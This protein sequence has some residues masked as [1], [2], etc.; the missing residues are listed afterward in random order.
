MHGCTISTGVLQLRSFGLSWRLSTL[1]RLFVILKVCK[2]SFMDLVVC[3]NFPARQCK[4]LATSYCAVKCFLC[5]CCR[6]EAWVVSTYIVGTKNPE[7]GVNTGKLIGNIA[8][9]C[10]CA[11]GLWRFVADRLA[12][13]RHIF[14]VSPLE[15]VVEPGIKI[16]Q[17]SVMVC[18][19]LSP[20]T[21]LESRKGATYSSNS[22]L[23]PVARAPPFAQSM[24]RFRRDFAPL[25]VGLRTLN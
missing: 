8:H 18:T 20:A 22:T 6:R 14:G 17:L 5:S 15:S 24:T 19:M 4:T 16:R 9:V 1:P 2:H 13:V 7:E 12:I 10:T 21:C 23:H 25:K 3:D 11:H